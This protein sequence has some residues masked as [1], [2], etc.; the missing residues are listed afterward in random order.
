VSIALAAVC[1]LALVLWGLVGAPLS[2]SAASFDVTSTADDG[3]V[4]TLRW[5]LTSAGSGDTIN[6]NLPG[7]GNTI[8]LQSAITVPVGVDIVGPGSASLTITRANTGDFNLFQFIPTSADQDYG[9]SGMTIDG[10]GGGSGS[11]ILAVPGAA[12]VDP[13]NI[14]V[15]DVTVQH[16][17]AP[18]APGLLA[19]QIAGDLE[20]EHSAFIENSSTGFGG[21]IVVDNIAGSTTFDTD[22]FQLNTGTA[23]GAV[24]VTDAQALT[25]ES[26]EFD[27]NSATLTQGGAVFATDISGAISITG[28]CG[29]RGNSSHTDGGGF[30]LD[31]DPAGFTIADSLVSGNSSGIRDVVTPNLVSG[32]GGGV[33]IQNANGATTISGSTFSEN[34]A[35]DG[36]GGGLFIGTISG[37]GSLG[38]SQSSFLD[39]NEFWGGGGIDVENVI[40]TSPVAVNVDS[41]TFSGNF[42]TKG[43]S[44]GS[45]ILL[46]NITSEVIVTN[47]TLDEEADLPGNEG[48][49]GLG[50]LLAADPGNT[51]ALIQSDT[52]NGPGALEVYDLEGG[53]IVRVENSILQSADAGDLAIDT[54]AVPAGSIVL[55]Y[56]LLTTAGVAAL[57]NE[58]GNQFSVADPQLGALSNN[59]GPTQTRLPALTSPA[60]NA[61]DPADVAP[62]GFD[63]RGIGFDRVVQRIDIGAVEIQT[64]TAAAPLPA[65]GGTIDWRVP[66]GGAGALILG[67]VLCV[68]AR[69]RRPAFG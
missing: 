24:W 20:V 56:D 52:I 45:S 3:S 39:N 4:G 55:D 12:L 23:G 38:V 46:Q 37:A 13:R 44:A 49:L 54:N 69:R 7:S 8:A 5:A 40:P 17:S 1:G 65:T 25:F 15:S 18:N 48:A 10:T 67:L 6:F 64:L 68:A 26:T 30:F 66:A 35:P 19:N 14:T 58:A 11:A 28:G 36:G 31:A 53:G 9:I 47:S 61:G 62:G 2:A 43:G 16:Q 50:G 51:M 21:S 27:G 22:Y 41:S 32:S 34:A 59:G 33:S 60:H 63:Q 29:F 42:S 57:D